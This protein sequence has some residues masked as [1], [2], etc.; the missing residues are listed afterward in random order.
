MEATYTMEA[1]FGITAAQ[2]CFD[3]VAVILWWEEGV[4]GSS[5]DLA[6]TVKNICFW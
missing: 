5:E 1:L 6:D 3:D 2:L 4:E